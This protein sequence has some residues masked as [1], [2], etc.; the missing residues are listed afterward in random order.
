M[1]NS[2]FS[3]KRLRPKASIFHD[4]LWR[5]S[6][7]TQRPQLMEA[8]VSSPATY[9]DLK[10][11]GLAA[12]S[13]NQIKQSVD[14]LLEAH[15]ISVEPDIEL[16][17]SLALAL[18]SYN[19]TRAAQVE[20]MER[21]DYPTSLDICRRILELDASSYDALFVSVKEYVEMKS[22]LEGLEAV[23]QM[24]VMYPSS[25]DALGLKVSILQKLDRRAE[26][27]EVAKAA[28]MKQPRNNDVRMLL[29]KALSWTNS[30]F[31]VIE[32]CNDV[33]EVEPNHVEALVCKADALIMLDFYDQADALFDKVLS[34]QPNH[35]YAVSRKRSVKEIK[36]SKMWTN[37]VHIF[38]LALAYN[39]VNL[40]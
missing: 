30:D 2:Y 33:L 24:I 18:H 9:A 32:V 26:A 29:A 35:E 39:F 20:V 25:L 8:L 12:L 14:L 4:I 1:I 34:I 40:S 15:K 11:R 19:R 7:H 21:D 31:E 13:N 10:S 5:N 17:S 37:S 38:F 23:N 16:L 6:F 27:I 28:L 3:L 36:R 22:Y